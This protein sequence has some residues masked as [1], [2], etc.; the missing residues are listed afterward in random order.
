MEGQKI[1]MINQ[2]ILK[3]ASELYVAPRISNAASRWCCSLELFEYWSDDEDVKKGKTKMEGQ[4]MDANGDHH[5][6]GHLIY[7]NQQNP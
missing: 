3:T 7:L 5:K 4:N 2:I 1:K 6:D